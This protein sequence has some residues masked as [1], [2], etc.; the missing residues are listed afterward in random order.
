MVPLKD[1]VPSRSFP[2]VN[3]ML[4][5]LNVFMFMAELSAASRGQVEAMIHDFGIVPARFLAYPGPRELSTLITGMFLHAGWLHLFSN[6]L[7]LYIFGDNIE[8][9]MGSAKYLVFYLLCGI[10][11]GVAHIVF[12]TSSTVPSVG[13]SGAIAGVLGAYLILFPHSTVITLI[14]VFFYPIFVEIPAV[15][16]LG[17]WFLSQMISGTMQIVHTIY[18]PEARAQGGVAWWAHAGGFIAGALLVWMFA[19]PQRKLRPRYADEYYPW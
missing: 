2:L 11:A 18:S 3:W 8:D 15:I 17:V 19:T 6:M 4:I 1:T 10:L 12:N 7:A 16:Y 14:P 9:R 13:A 5:G